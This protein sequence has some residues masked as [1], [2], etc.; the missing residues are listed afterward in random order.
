[1]ENPKNKKLFCLKK[2]K[3]KKQTHT[4]TTKLATSEMGLTKTFGCGLS[5]FETTIISQNINIQERPFQNPH[6]RFFARIF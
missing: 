2:K 3:T 1:M 4:Q 5:R 6:V